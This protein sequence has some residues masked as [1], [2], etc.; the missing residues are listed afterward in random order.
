VDPRPH[1]IAIVGCGV[2]G[3]TSA[4]LLARQGHAVTLFE[5]SAAVGPAGAGVLLQ[6]SG[7]LVLQRLGLLDRVAAHAERIDRLYARTHRGHTLVDLRY[8]AV[9]PEMHALGLHRGDL[10]S[11]LHA[12]AVAAGAKILLN[13]RIIR[14]TN[15][16]R[17]IELF[18]GHGVSRGSFDLLLAA[19][20]SRSELRRTSQLR[21]MI[22]DYPHGALWALGTCSGIRNQLFQVTRGT[23][24]LAGLLPTGENRCSLF[25]SLEKRQRES[26][27]ARGFAAWRNDVLAL[28]P[29]AEEIF[30]GLNSFDELRFTTYLHVHM[31]RWH[32]G[33]C[34]FLGDAA[35]SMSPHLGQ[36]INLALLD[37]FTIADALAATPTPSAAFAH[38]ARLRR[39]HT[40]F[41]ATITFLMSPFFQS[42]GMIKGWARDL[43]LPFLPRMPLV[44]R[45]QMLLT[46]TGLK[47]S[48]LAGR[49][50]L[51]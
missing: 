8:A 43:A 45:T 16:P 38:Y 9:S 47:R 21:A 35:H 14:F 25:W 7:Q 40:S 24:R 50:E 44:G 27:F 42:R 5:Q 22:Y 17:R 11:I 34:L 6:P 2:A 41:Y 12:E 23:Q 13:T 32:T 18:D 39:S 36:G 29:Q 4:I 49:I 20:G 48:Y 51:L 3:L 28:I 31:P 1:S 37:G 26:L 10:F 46:M 33:R 15:H 19:D 30:A